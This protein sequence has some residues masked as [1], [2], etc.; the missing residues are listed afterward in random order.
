MWDLIGRIANYVVTFVVS[1]VLTRLLLPEEF[2][3]FG[4]L[5]AITLFAWVV[6]EF[7]FR[8]AIVQA[9][10]IS[11]TQLSSVL[12]ISSLIGVVLTVALITAGPVVE[13]FYAIPG[14]T[15]Y[16]IGISPVFLLN[17]LLAVPSALVQRELRL[18]ELSIFTVGGSVVAGIVS[19]ILALRGFGVWSLIVANLVSSLTSVV[20]CY[21]ISRWKPT[22]ALD[23]SSIKPLFKFGSRIFLSSILDV[24]FTRADV[25]IIGKLFDINTLGFYTRAQSLD[26]QVKMFSVGTIVT[27]MLSLFSRFQSDIERLRSIYYRAMHFVSFAT[28]GASGLLVLIAHD[29]FLVLFSAT[30][31]QSVPYFQIMAV[32]SAA[33][34]LNYVML[35]LISGRGNSKAVL[36][37]EVLKKV[38]LCA[39][40]LTF[41]GGGIFAFL[42]A[43]GV[44]HIVSMLINMAFVKKEI[45][46]PVTKQLS[47]VGI[48]AFISVLSAGVAYVGVGV[49]DLPV[50]PRLLLSVSLFSF[51]NVGL[52]LLLRTS[53]SR[54]LID[55]LGGS[56]LR[57]PDSDVDNGI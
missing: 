14:L 44:V 38:F 43:L 8:S 15:Y 54:E 5:I 4:I 56:F 25:F 20:A 46:E 34:P 45:D 40:Y 11:Q 26:L 21:A 51:V 47:V 31:L 18:K 10:T 33:Y 12:I 6:Q 27:V 39:A 1:V 55:R 17:G 37:L 2:G 9:K 16:F 29:M 32:T 53:G 36:R 35:N 28:V 24:V 42:I 41:F 7:G 52:N 48:Y 19:V 3:A 22:L 50:I 30:W 23:I 57:R 49:I 13:A